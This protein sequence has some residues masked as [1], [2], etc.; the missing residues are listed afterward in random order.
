MHECGYRPQREQLLEHSIF[1]STPGPRP[2]VVTCAQVTAMN[3]AHLSTTSLTLIHLTCN[4]RVH[5]THAHIIIKCATYDELLE[6]DDELLE[7][8]LDE[9]DDDDECELLLLD[10]DDEELED[11]DDDELEHDELLLLEELDD[12]HDDDELDDE[13]LLL[14]ELL[15][16]DDMLLED[17]LLLLEDLW[18]QQSQLRMSYACLCHLGWR[19]LI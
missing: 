5:T 11:D 1:W 4:T 7:L 6:L 10:D 8:E 14:D 13:L 12:E 3:M 9:Q 17:E 19:T 15:L 2:P 18:I 16:D